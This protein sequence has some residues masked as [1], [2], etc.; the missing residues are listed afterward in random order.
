MIIIRVSVLVRILEAYES[1]RHSHLAS[2]TAEAIS[3]DELQLMRGDGVRDINL[4]QTV[5]ARDNCRNQ[6]LV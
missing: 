2:S 4:S 5:P 3:K 1:P 6:S